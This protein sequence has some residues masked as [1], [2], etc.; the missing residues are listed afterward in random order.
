MFYAKFDRP[1]QTFFIIGTEFN[2]KIADSGRIDSLGTSYDYLSIMHYSKNAFGYGRATT[3]ITKDPAFQ[4]KIGQRGGFS[5]IDIKQ[6]NLM[7]C[8]G[9][10]VHKFYF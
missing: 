7:Y 4:D 2:F 6:I 10:M 9:G 8:Q 5:D 1:N 3:I